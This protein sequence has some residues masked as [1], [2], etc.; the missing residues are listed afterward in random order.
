MSRNIQPY[1][2][3][4]SPEKYKRKYSEAHVIL[5]L[6]PN[7]LQLPARKWGSDHLIGFRVVSLCSG[8]VLP[9]LEALAP[10]PGDLEDLKEWPNIKRL[11]DGP[12]KQDLLHKSCYEIEHENGSLGT[13]LSRL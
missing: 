13:F 12:K 1:Y 3:K 6:K 8:K 10:E 9:I 2:P 7:L 4:R 5:D 11:I